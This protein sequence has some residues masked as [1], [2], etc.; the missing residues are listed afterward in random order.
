MSA[1][2]LAALVLCAAVLVPAAHGQKKEIVQ[3]QRDLALMQET[4]RL[5]NSKID[6][7]LIALEALVKQS[8]D[9]QDKLTAGQAVIERRLGT[10]DDALSEPQRST[11]AKVD[12]LADQFSSLRA[13]VEEMGASV[14][15]L[16]ADVRDIKTHL[17]T[18]PPPVEGEEGEVTEASAV[19]ASE[20]IFE[21]GMADYLRGN[22]A[23]ARGQ[24]QDYLTLYGGHS[25]APD[26][27]YYLAETFYSSA[28]YEEAARQ[29]DQVYKRYPLS[30]AA[31]DS[32]FKKGQSLAN[33]RGRSDEALEAY[34]SVMERF[35]DSN[36]SRLARAELNRL[37][38]SKPSPGL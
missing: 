31:P 5:N 25:K 32:L 14:E 27:Q 35:P 12:M 7:R 29:F 17:T 16:Q 34:E 6:E 33:L 37:R 19:Q 38:N 22:I 30:K 1:R 15:R 24:F 21:G 8:V 9:K 28:E 13:T 3:F 11:A 10:L 36:A 20:A 18:L 26:A 23:S 2:P 4:L